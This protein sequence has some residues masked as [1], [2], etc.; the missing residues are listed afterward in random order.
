MS[1][2]F[3]QTGTRMS[4]AVIHNNTIYLAGQVADDATASMAEQT[5]Q[6]LNNIDVL[7]ASVGSSKNN[8][9]SAQI[10]VTDMTEFDEMNKVWDKWVTP[11][12]APARACTQAQLANPAW[13]V[14]IMVIAALPESP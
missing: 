7:L 2:T 8:L 3:H 6:T 9:L 10:W 14:E 12:K 5:K 13:K 4:Q 1:T 11:N